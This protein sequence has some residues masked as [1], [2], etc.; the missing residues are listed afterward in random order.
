MN[1]QEQGDEGAGDGGLLLYKK[2]S[3]NMGTP[4]QRLSRE[5]FQPE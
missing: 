2:G 1:V 5:E 4:A 3:L